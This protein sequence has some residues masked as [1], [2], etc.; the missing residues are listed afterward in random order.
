M[1]EDVR[2]GFDIDGVLADFLT[3]FYAEVERVLGVKLDPSR[4]IKFNEHMDWG[5]LSISDKVIPIM[6]K[7]SPLFWMG[8]DPI[9]RADMDHVARISREIPTYFVTSRSQRSHESHRN[10]IFQTKA[11]L[12]RFGVMPAGIILSNV[13]AG[14][15]YNLGVT[16]FIED[17]F[18]YFQDIRMHAKHVDCYLLDKSYNR[19]V[20]LNGKRIRIQDVEE[21]RRVSS[22]L[23]FIN[24]AYKEHERRKSSVKD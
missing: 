15:L 22:V 21:G 4:Q 16:H 18:R 14:T 9:D 23:E 5:S 3:P 12:A 2:V 19:V 11:W 20:D 24:I 17:R 13:K 7:K 6:M 10:V 1:I 8:M